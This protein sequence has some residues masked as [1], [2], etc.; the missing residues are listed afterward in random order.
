MKRR[1]ISIREQRRRVTA[2]RNLQRG[3]RI[4]MRRRGGR[5]ETRA[6]EKKVIEVGQRERGER[7]RG[8]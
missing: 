7:Q 2:G 5:E 6:V 3:R 1:K 4:H 8:G